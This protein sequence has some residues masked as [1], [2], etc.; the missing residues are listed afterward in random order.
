MA[1]S[2]AEKIA[3]SAVE[4]V[5][6]AN[7]AVSKMLGF[8]LVNT[9]PIQSSDTAALAK[10]TPDQKKLSALNAGMSHNAAA[11][12]MG[13]GAQA[14]YGQTISCTVSRCAADVHL[15][16]AGSTPM[17]TLGDKCYQETL[18]GISKA[19]NAQSSPGLIGTTVEILST[20]PLGAA[21][22][23]SA[24]NTNLSLSVAGIQEAYSTAAT[25]FRPLIPLSGSKL[26]A[27]NQISWT[28]TQPNGSVCKDSPYVWTP[29]DWAGKVDIAS[30]TSIRVYP[31]LLA[32]GDA[33][34]IYNWTVT[35]SASGSVPVSRSF[36]VAY[37][38]QATTGIVVEGLSSPQFTAGT[39]SVASTTS[40][41]VPALTVTGQNLGAVERIEWRWSGAATGSAT[42]RKSDSIWN[43]KVTYTADGRL[44]LLP[45]VIEDNPAWKGT[46][47]WTGTLINAVG[48][49]QNITFSVV[50]QPSTPTPTCPLP[51]LLTSGVCITPTTTTA[52]SIT[53]TS[54]PS[55][56]V[57]T[58]YA[59]GVVVS[60]GKTPYVWSVSSGLPSGLYINSTTGAIYGTPSVAGT[61]GFSVTVTDS[62][63]PQKT[64]LKA[65]SLTVTP[66]ATPQ[67]PPATT[68]SSPSPGSTSSP[69]PT[70]AS[71]TVG[72]SWGGV[73]GA[74][75]Y[76]FGVRDMV[77]NALVV[78]TT[79]TGTSYSASLAAGGQYRWNVAACNA[80]G[81][82]SYTTVLYFKTP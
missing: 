58:G 34:G 7:G 37:Q 81:C 41:V 19:V 74:T 45:I 10:A 77:S 65:L 8:D 29:S 30:D 70:Q 53:T 54:L 42:W 2:L 78:N 24:I 12:G 75:Y 52:L 59:Q 68:P 80:S 44:I 18:E 51:Q 79:T 69:G 67:T 50:Y 9:T 60:G 56:S 13:C 47:I 23:P 20:V 61:Y 22:T 25:P 6:M 72:L 46:A 48:L 35:I 43:N 62:S 1:V 36:T 33:T 82:S 31:T 4:A 28:C 11:D 73:S 71:S 39:T 16:T 5:Q 76:D 21:P 63:S 17:M 15:D 14:T 49:S 64:T 27:I 57:G 3:G 26:S 55:A 32:L 66:S 38:Q 40:P